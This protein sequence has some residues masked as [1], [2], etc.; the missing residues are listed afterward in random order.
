MLAEEHYDPETN[1]ATAEQADD[2]ASVTGGSTGQNGTTGD[3][4]VQIVLTGVTQTR[5]GGQ[6]S[7]QRGW[8]LSSMDNVQLGNW[9][10]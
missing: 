5:I 6:V 10:E 3:T 8:R 1:G 4:D 9:M 2:D 7:P